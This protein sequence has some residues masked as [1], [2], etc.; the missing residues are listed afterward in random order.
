MK[1]YV[2]NIP[3]DTNRDELIEFY[4]QYGDVKEVYIPMDVN[5]GGPRGFAFVTMPEED[6]VK[7]IDETNGVMY[8]GRTLAVSKPL[9]RGEKAPPRETPTRTKLYV[10]NLSFYTEL[11]TVQQLFGEYGDVYDCYMPMDRETGSSRGFAFV[12]MSPDDA[13][14]AMG[15]I[16]GYELDGRIVRVNEAQPKGQEPVSKYDDGE[17]GDEEYN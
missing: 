13:A 1:I 7:A 5:T 14:T 12:T 10:G 3:F 15:D 16:D 6:A 9:P 4:E 11:D 17:F 8:Q 2:G